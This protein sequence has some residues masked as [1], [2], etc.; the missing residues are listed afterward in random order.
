VPLSEEPETFA[1]E[2]ATAEDSAAAEAVDKL[3][4]PAANPL[5]LG[6]LLEHDGEDVADEAMQAN[7]HAAVEQVELLTLIGSALEK[8]PARERELIRRHYFEQCEFRV[9]ANELAVSPGRVSQ[10]HAQALLRIRELLHSSSE[11]QG[12]A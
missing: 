8:L 9:I 12:S 4:P 10:L 7:P 6:F 3:A 5:A 1:D 11:A 2:D